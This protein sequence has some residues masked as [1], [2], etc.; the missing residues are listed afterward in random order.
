MALTIFL[1]ILLILAKIVENLRIWATW[2]A[3]RSRFNTTTTRP[4]VFLIVIEE[5]ALAFLNTA[6]VTILCRINFSNLRLDAN[7]SKNL[8][9]NR[10][11]LVIARDAIFLRTNKTSDVNFAWIQANFFSQESEE[12]TNLLLFEVIAERP[13]TKHLKD[14]RMARIANIVNILQAEAWLRISQASAIF[15]LLTKKIWHQWLHTRARK[16]SRWVVFENQGGRRNLHM[17]FTFH[18]F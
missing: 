9:P 3:N 11:G 14:C 18:K 12:V 1:D 13:V 10:S 5:N 6:L 16:K 2:V 7:L 4:P 15:V 17:A 8:L